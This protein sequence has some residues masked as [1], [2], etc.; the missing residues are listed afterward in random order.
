MLFPAWSVLVMVLFGL[1]GCSSFHEVTMVSHGGQDSESSALKHSVDHAMGLPKSSSSSSPPVEAAS[2]GLF[3]S[4]EPTS[5]QKPPK[6]IVTDILAQSLDETSLPWTVED[7]FFE[8]DQYV[9]RPEA[10]RVLTVNAK[11]LMK[12]YPGR[13]LILQGHCDERGTEEYNL[14]LGG[15]RATAV[16]EFLRDLGV[17]PENMRVLSLGKTQPFCLSRNADCFQKNRRVHFV[18]K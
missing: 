18:F 16:K 7:V 11:V 13:E 15:R 8:Y 5:S 12:R 1:T 10:M 4:E 6:E 17:P 14:I 2:T 9:I 3:S